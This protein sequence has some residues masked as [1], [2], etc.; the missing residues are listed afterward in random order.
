MITTGSRG[1]AE[2]VPGGN[3][4]K[5]QL[6][7]GAPF[8]ERRKGRSQTRI[9]FFVGYM[10]ELRLRIVDVV[11]VHASKLHVSKRLFQLVL[12]IRGRHAV[13][14]ANNILE[15]RNSRFDECFLNVATNVSRRRAVKRQITAL[16]A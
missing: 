16:G 10:A 1:H 12:Q 2:S 11:N 4:I 6:T 7:F 9:E 15:T 3:T 8:L 5:L 14:A 13:A